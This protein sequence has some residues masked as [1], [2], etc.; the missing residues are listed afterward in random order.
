MRKMREPNCDGRQGWNTE[1]A[2]RA[3]GF[4]HGKDGERAFEQSIEVG[5]GACLVKK[6]RAGGG[7]GSAA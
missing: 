3:E 2:G 6:G 5:G 4:R 1:T 7:A